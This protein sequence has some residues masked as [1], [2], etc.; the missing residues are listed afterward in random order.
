MSDSGVIPP[1]AWLIMG[2]A[3]FAVS[4]AGAV[5]EMIEGISGLSKQLGGCKQPR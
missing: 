3:L 1:H 4:S 2:V 5:F